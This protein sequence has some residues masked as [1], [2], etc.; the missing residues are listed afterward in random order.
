MTGKGAGTAVIT[1]TYGTLASKE[2]TFIVEVQP[3]TPARAISI[4]GSDTVTQFSDIQLAATVV[5]AEAAGTYEW[6]SS[7]ED[8]LTVDNS[9]NVTGVR[10][11]TATVTVSF[12]S[13]VD[14]S[15]FLR[16]KM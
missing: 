4:S 8:I 6:S 3:A 9:G 1:H 13:A 7:N 10:Q 14:G 11:G 5:P 16:L 15:K 2:E 12:I